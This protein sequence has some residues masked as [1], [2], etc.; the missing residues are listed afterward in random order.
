MKA[1]DVGLLKLRLVLGGYLVVHG[2]Q[3]LW[4]SFD[5]PGIE[6][7]AQGFDHLGLTPGAVTARMAG[8]SELVGGALTAAGALSPLGPVMLAGTMTVASVVHRKQGPLSQAGGYELPLTNLA[9]AVG[10][11][12]AGP[13][14]L[15]VDGLLGRSAPR[16]LIRLAVLIGVASATTS[17]LRLLRHAPPDPV[18]DTGA[19]DGGTPDTTIADEVDDAEAVEVAGI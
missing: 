11:I 14:S 5:G 6:T 9:A 19:A 15:S 7:T 13:G 8:G 16:W 1:R 4:G 18:V 10:L 2:A 12:A 17:I 3:K